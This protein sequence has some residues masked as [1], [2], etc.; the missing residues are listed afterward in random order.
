MSYLPTNNV[1]KSGSSNVPTHVAA[2]KQSAAGNP[3]SPSTSNIHTQPAFIR[4]PSV[5]VER[6]ANALSS[7]V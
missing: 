6:K 3:A 5:N 2:L 7:M 4:S 1:N